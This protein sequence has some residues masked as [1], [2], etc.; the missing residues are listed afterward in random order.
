[1]RKRNILTTTLAFIL[2][3]AGVCLF[4]LK[5]NVRA[6]VTIENYVGDN[7]TF[8]SEYV[9]DISGYRGNTPIA[10][11]AKTEGYTDWLFAG[12]YSEKECTQGQAIRK[13]TTDG[14]AWAKY[15]SSDLLT[16]K[17]Q[18]KE[19]VQNPDVEKT[20]LKVVSA[21]DSLAYDKVG[22]R[23]QY[24]ENGT[25]TD[26]TMQTV[27]KRIS[28][29]EK[30]GTTYQYNPKVVDADACYFLTATIANISREYYEDTFCVKPY[31]VTLDGTCVYGEC[32]YVKVSDS[33]SNVVN[34]PVKAD[35][36]AS[37]KELTVAGKEIC[38]Y[39]YFA[40]ETY[41]ALMVNEED[42][43]ALASA[44]K[45]HISDGTSVV[46]R[47]PYVVYVGNGDCT[48]YNVREQEKYVLLSL[49]DLYGFAQV[50]NSGIDFAGKTVYLGTDI[51]LNDGNSLQWK[52]NAPANR[53]T[54]IGTTKE[55][56]FNGTF[57]GYLDTVSG[58]YIEAVG[59]YEGL[60][61]YVESEGTVQNL[62]IANSFYTSNLAKAMGSAIGYLRGDAK[63]I[64]A[65]EDVHLV[66][67]KS[68]TVT[69][70]CGTGGV[71]GAFEREGIETA[72][73]ISG[74]W[75]A[76]TAYS[77]AASVSGILGHAYR[78]IL[79]FENCLNTGTITGMYQGTDNS[80]YTYASGLMGGARSWN[81]ST[82]MYVYM[83]DCLTIGKVNTGGIYAVGSAVG[84]TLQATFR[85]KN[86]Y[87]TDDIV[88]VDGEEIY[89]SGTVTGFGN[90][91]VTAG[92]LHGRPVKVT[93]EEICGK[94]GYVALDLDYACAKNSDGVWAAI[95]GKTPELAIFTEEK[96]ITN[97]ESVERELTGWYYNAFTPYCK[98]Y[99]ISD[100]T[101][102]H[103]VIDAQTSYVISN[104]D[105]LRGLRKLVNEGIDDFSDIVNT[106]LG[107]T[108][109]GRTVEL[110]NDIVMYEGNATDW[111]EG[112]NLPKYSWI[113][114]GL[115]DESQKF[116]GV[117][118]G[119]G[120]T[121]SGVYAVDEVRTTAE[122]NYLGVFAI[123]A[124]NS[125]IQNLRLVNSYFKQTVT[126]GFTG[127]IACDIQ[128]KAENLYSNAIIDSYGQQVGGITARINGLE[129]EVSGSAE[130]G[131]LVMGRGSM[132]MNNCWFDGQIYV[133]NLSQSSHFVGGVA[134]VLVQG[135]GSIS[136]SL[137][138]GKI[139]SI[140]SDKTVYIGGI[141][142]S[143]MAQ[144]SIGY[145]SGSESNL[146]INSCI[147]AGKI[148]APS[149]FRGA[150][151]GRVLNSVG[152]GKANN[153]Y[154]TLKNVFATRECWQT[155]I[156]VKGNTTSSGV[157]ATATV[158]GATIQTYDTDRLIGYC[159][160][161]NTKDSLDFTNSWSMR[162]S[163]VPIP[164]TMEDLVSA[165]SLTDVAGLTAEI[166]LDYWGGTLASAVNYG[167]GNY[168]AS[169][170]ATKGKYQTYLGTL[171]KLGFEK[172]VDNSA[173]TLDD[174]GVCN[175]IYTKESGDWVLNVTYVGGE[176][177]VYVSVS[178]IGKEKLSPNLLGA[179]Q[180]GTK[181]VM[182]SMLQLVNS[183]GYGNGFLFQ[184]P[185]GHFI[186]IDGGMSADGPTLIKYLSA[187]ANGG[188]VYIDA[189]VISH[190]HGDHCAA[191]NQLATK[192]ALRE[193]IYLE[194]VYANESS[195]YSKKSD[196]SL[197]TGPMD[198]AYLGAMSLTKADGSQPDVV[199]L[200]MGERFYFN[201]VTLDIIQ[202]QE[203][204]PV[205]YYND[206]SDPDKFN[207]TSTNCMFTIN[208]TGDKI[209]TGGDSTKANMNYIMKAY[210]GITATAKRYNTGNGWYTDTDPEGITRTK[211]KTLSD[212]SV[213][214]AYHHGKNTTNAF[215]RYLVGNETD[216]YT[217][218]FAMFPF[219]QMMNPKLYETYIYNGT[220]YKN[221][222]WMEDNSCVFNYKMEAVNN[223]LLANVTQGFYT[224]GY[225]D[226]VTNSSASNPHGTV[227]LYFTSTGVNTQVRKSWK[228]GFTMEL[229]E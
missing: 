83:S 75:F 71:V 192:P 117:F 6:E 22:F 205:D 148:N 82:G 65:R 19:D 97:L 43:N 45:Y 61:G 29:S 73:T 142:G 168:V 38:E 1:M 72:G 50:V 180:E 4:G 24:Q 156:N 69:G 218:K 140:T 37:L 222:Y 42:V 228:N 147:S 55:T 25:L 115:N 154:V 146:T 198:N 107:K 80:L 203:Q 78:G 150:V 113:P 223:S 173:G 85:V 54:P 103:G 177:K 134:G 63:N 211:T 166:G 31:W 87:T 58:I 189:W 152:G 158:T 8:I 194:A 118:D 33:F 143:A 176:S 66:N 104:A 214:I 93:E 44:T 48:W 59:N 95:E 23:I 2:I 221:R 129:Y 224:Y 90:Y 99:S 172:Y 195:N 227:E 169:Y 34:I 15:V 167:V 40:G 155:A 114:I 120:H 110:A 100:G 159:T 202:A 138:T 122:F 149:G 127:S 108:I 219:H 18:V 89:N 20:N 161:E 126:D 162:A 62:Q 163:G 35:S 77:Q 111:A 179:T 204:L 39:R 213:F 84:R 26:S 210:D 79:N 116:G 157:T 123:T 81:G 125:T 130:T 171:E 136:N 67:T 56:A 145:Q 52:E 225:E 139:E 30:T 132:A 9:E 220:T 182:F 96:V 178:T 181:D 216:A 185:N 174:D 5:Q 160:E 53:W 197:M 86:V 76:G 212:I 226:S 12:W 74:C 217:F 200:H 133:K 190:F 109:S 196:G 98:A 209:F 105:E 229:F 92:I 186:V 94:D 206:F 91:S 208:A 153:T 60:F 121:L 144:S 88:N 70:D 102:W 170:S 11:K 201:G 57:D 32:R 112:K 64:Y 215:T 199:R 119:K 10:P 164:K 175:A 28:A 68:R 106:D 46:H 191:F 188:P 184:L 193:N 47:N 21:I 124:P 51:A 17:C 137:F 131:N 13:T 49:S 141:V 14:G 3:C 128:G 207:A 7:D 101:N 187:L 151:M 183:S 165:K 16:V 27:F 41:G 36:R 135:T